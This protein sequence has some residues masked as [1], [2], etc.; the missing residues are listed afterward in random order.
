[1]KTSMQKA[2]NA[3]KKRLEPRVI[4]YCMGD[5]VIYHAVFPQKKLRGLLYR[6]VC[7]LSGTETDTSAFQWMS[8]DEHGRDQ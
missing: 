8:H 3:L 4:D 6:L 1:M 5:T 7:R 2:L